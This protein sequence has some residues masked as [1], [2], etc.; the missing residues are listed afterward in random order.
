[1][2]SPKGAQDAT[3]R[4]IL[5]AAAAVVAGFATQRAGAT[6][7]IVENGTNWSIGNGE[8][9]IVYNAKTSSTAA[10]SANITSIEM[11]GG[12]TQLLDSNDQQLYPEYAGADPPLG[13]GV[14]TSGYQVGANGNYID[15]WT[16]TQ[17]QGTATSAYSYAFHYVMFNNSPDIIC[18]ETLNHSATDPQEGIGQGQFLAR[19]NPALFNNTY[20]YNVS[21]N[22]PGP[23]TATLDQYYQNPSNPSAPYYA[24]FSG[25]TARQVSDATLDLTGTGLAGDWGSNIY[26]KYDY[27]SYTQFLQ[28]TTEFGSQYDV[29]AIYT[30]MDTLNGGPTK[31]ML[32]FTNN[33]SMIEYLSGHYGDANYSY[34]PPAGVATNKIYGPYAFSFTP[35]DGQT[36]AQLYQDAVN[37]IPTLDA[38]YQTD[39]E[40]VSSGY[41]T[42]PY[43]GS[44]QIAAS[45]SA[46]WSSDVNNNTVVLSDPGKMFQ[47]SNLGYQYWAQLSPNGTASI[48]N[49]APGDYRMTLYELGQWGETRIDG[50]TVNSGQITI[51]QNVKFTPENFSAAAPIWTIGT[52]DRSAHEF[53]DGSNVAVSYTNANA[54]GTRVTTN[55][56]TP[57]GDLRQFDGAYNYW[58]E[59]QELGTPGQVVYYATAVNGHAATN[60]PL[61]WIANQWGEFDPGVYDPSDNTTDGYAHGYGPGGGAPAYVMAAGGP[62]SYK[63]LPW[64]VN[65]TCTQTQLNQG[66]YVDLSVGLAANEAS[67]IVTLNGHQEI[68][69]YGNSSTDAMVRSGDSGVYKFLVFEFPTSDLYGAGVED[70]F[71]FGVS[72]NDGVMYDALRMEITNTSANPTTRGWYDYEY[73]TGSNTQT[74]ANNAAALTATYQYAPQPA[75]LTWSNAGSTGDGVTWDTATQNWNNGLGETLYS[76][77]S[78]VSLTDNNNGNYNVSLNTTVSPGPILV[79]N[80]LG[81]YTISGSGG[82]AG[83][84]SLT[85][86][87]SD[88]LTLSTVNTYSGGTFVN[89][90]VLVVA[91]DGALPNGNVSVSSVGKLVLAVAT[92]ATQIQSV[93][94]AT[95]G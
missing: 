22:N 24:Q 48:S 36:G 37:S 74:A 65:F 82:I 9:N 84:S 70:Q 32:Q 68:W 83:T 28:A 23:Q 88:T 62:G 42:Q 39:A 89:G 63:G 1:M 18:Y 49:V 17:S 87:G 25:Q 20:Q 15:F 59:E 54:T 79:N 78:G 61:D 50:V 64:D 33:I 34:D 75:A 81:N 2:H 71:T 21:V 13:G 44:V 14:E 57:G 73:I 26:T 16:S 60:N 51:P 91:T 46:G 30:S 31:Q 53:L 95:G 4:R 11:A 3:T 80:S 76:D 86:V 35:T 52:P 90:G 38:D 94:I 69:H 85:K 6:I 92:G 56:V 66:Q 72:Q 40:L 7:S 47:E 19:V 55:G 29:S 41:V 45:N 8:L 5:R 67:L 12:S 43:R 27:S 10:P 58:Q 93:S 77:G